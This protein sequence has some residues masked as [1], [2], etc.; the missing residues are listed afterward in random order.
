VCLGSRPA[1]FPRSGPRRDDDAVAVGVGDLGHALAPGLVGGLGEHLDAV[2]VE[3][4]D[5]GV[6]VVG[7]EPD[8]ELA[9][10]GRGLGG[11][12]GADAEKGNTQYLGPPP[13]GTARDP[14]QDVRQVVGWVVLMELA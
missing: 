6:A 5:G 14:S 7:V 11:G 3:V 4:A 12:V 9:P 2:V 1:A 13:G 8:G 10:A